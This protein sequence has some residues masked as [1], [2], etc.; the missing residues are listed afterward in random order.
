MM[1]RVNVTGKDKSSIPSSSV[2]KYLNASLYRLDCFRS[3]GQREW[4][5]AKKL[6]AVDEVD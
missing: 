3:K 5:F 4:R 1:A 2:M 6:C